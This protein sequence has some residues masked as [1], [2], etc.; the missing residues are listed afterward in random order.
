MSGH[1]AHRHVV[2]LAANDE[3]TLWDRECRDEQ[4][5]DWLDD[6]DFEHDPSWHDVGGEGG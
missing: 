5:P 4:C 6:A 2:P 3:V 1:R